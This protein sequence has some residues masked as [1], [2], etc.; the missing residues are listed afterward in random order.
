MSFLRPLCFSDEWR[1]KRLLW[2][3]RERD[4]QLETAP[5]SWHKRVKRPEKSSTLI[6]FAHFVTYFTPFSSLSVGDCYTK[7]F[8]Q[9]THPI[10]SSL[11]CIFPFSIKCSRSAGVALHQSLEAPLLREAFSSTCKQRK[12]D[13]TRLRTMPWKHVLHLWWRCDRKHATLVKQLVDVNIL[14]VLSERFRAETQF[15]WDFIILSDS[16]Y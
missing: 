5:F 12:L 7:A 10:P 8:N 1:Q 3:N 4:F 2:R 14:T 6:V 11:D 13:G 16:L 9:R 15:L